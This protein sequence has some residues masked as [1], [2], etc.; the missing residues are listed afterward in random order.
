MDADARGIEDG[1]LL[2]IFN[3]RGEIRITATVTET[4]MP[5]VVNVPQGGCFRPDEK[6]ID[7][8][9]CPN[10]VCNDE[11]SPCGA[12]AWHT[13]LVQVEKAKD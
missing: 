2:R 11:Y 13:N 1:D 7:R 3:D 10:T 12:Y 5:G 9:G 6:G 8:G 4:I